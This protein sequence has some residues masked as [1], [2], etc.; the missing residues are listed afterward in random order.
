MSEPKEQF[1]SEAESIRK[2]FVDI[3]EEIETLGIGATEMHYFEG[4]I[5]DLIK[6]MEKAKIP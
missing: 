5:E 4:E 3:V 1:F 6:L 2:E